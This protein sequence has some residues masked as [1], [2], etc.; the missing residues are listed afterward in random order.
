VPVTPGWIHVPLVQQVV[1]VP[2]ALAEQKLLPP[3]AQQPVVSA[4]QPIGVGV[5]EV[6]VVLVVVVV[7]Q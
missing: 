1:P 6:E 7:P 5:V 2:L 3:P 4:V